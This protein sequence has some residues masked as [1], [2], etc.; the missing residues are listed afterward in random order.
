MSLFQC[1]VEQNKHYIC[2]Q[3]C[4]TIDA[5]HKWRTQCIRNIP[6]L[7]NYIGQLSSSTGVENKPKFVVYNIIP[8][9]ANKGTKLK[10]IL[11]K[12]TQ[13]T[14]PKKHKDKKGLLKLNNMLLNSN[15]IQQKISLLKTDRTVGDTEMNVSNESNEVDMPGQD[16]IYGDHNYVGSLTDVPDTVESLEVSCDVAENLDEGEQV[17]YLLDENAVDEFI[18]AG[19][20]FSY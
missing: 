13:N 7:L 19:R 8:E 5:V 11:P 1:F 15:F 20:L 18:V 10:N 4:Q 9:D 17:E 16:V 2:L 3:C 12:T 14:S 6:T